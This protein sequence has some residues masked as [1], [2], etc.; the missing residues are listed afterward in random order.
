MINIIDSNSKNKK[1]AYRYSN[2]KSIKRLELVINIDKPKSL[3]FMFNNCRNLE[4]LNLTFPNYDKI[5]M[6]RMFSFCENLK[7]LTI[8]N[9]NIIYSNVLFKSAQFTYMF[10]GCKS[11]KYLNLSNFYNIYS[12]NYIDKI[13]IHCNIKYLNIINANDLSTITSECDFFYIKSKYSKYYN[14]GRNYKYLYIPILKMNI[15]K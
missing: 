2:C 9:L 5:I 11:L 7:Y 14:I 10:Y 3:S 6:K 13:F 12:Y 15:Y 4:Y 1:L 8:N